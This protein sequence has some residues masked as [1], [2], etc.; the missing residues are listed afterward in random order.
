MQILMQ[1]SER[2]TRQPI[3]DFW[4]ASEETVFSGQSRA[5]VYRWWSKY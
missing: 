3:H 2:L 4:K 5:E 1:N